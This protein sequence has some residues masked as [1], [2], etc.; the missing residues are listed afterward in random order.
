MEADNRVASLK[1]RLRRMQEL[2][3][4]GDIERGEY[5]AERRQL[6]AELAKL[7]VTRGKS[8]HLNRVAQFLGDVSLAWEAGDQE[9]RNRLAAELF[10]SVWVRDRII[11]SVTPKPEMS[12]F[13]DL[14]YHEAVKKGVA[15]TA[16]TGFEPAFSALTG[17][18]VSPLH[19]G[20]VF[21]SLE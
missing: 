11:V 20:A 2:Y 5:L 3:S 1:A 7:T 21:L 10:D 9:Q 6:Q 18:H 12:P 15:V 14:V 13:F 16:P 19:H 17:P 8:D 4:W